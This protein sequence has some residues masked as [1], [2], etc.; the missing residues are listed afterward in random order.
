MNGWFKDRVLVEQS[1]VKD[2]KQT[3]AQ[4][5]VAPRSRRSPK[6]SSGIDHQSA[7]RGPEAVG[8]ALASAAS[9]ETIDASTVDFLAS[10]IARAMERGNLE[11]ASSSVAATSGAVPRARWPA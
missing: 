6:W 10:E 5:L 1:Y 8:R 3:I 7:P 2:E 9:D 11:L 4:F